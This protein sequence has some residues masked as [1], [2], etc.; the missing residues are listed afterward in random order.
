[1]RKQAVQEYRSGLIQRLQSSI[2]KSGNDLGKDSCPVT[3]HFA[4]GIYCREIFI[5]AG[6][7]LVGARHKY[8]HPNVLSKGKVQVYTE[9]EGL[10]EYTAPYT[11]ISVAGVKRV[12]VALEDSVWTTFHSCTSTDLAEIEREVIILEEAL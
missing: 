4:P 1:M 7:C 3:H 8:A 10:V 5:P 6:I 2:I 9:H 12:I 11:Y